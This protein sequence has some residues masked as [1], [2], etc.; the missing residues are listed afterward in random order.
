MVSATV[1]PA[2]SPALVRRDTFAPA[3]AV[4]EAV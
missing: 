3:G 1:P 2:A 4:N